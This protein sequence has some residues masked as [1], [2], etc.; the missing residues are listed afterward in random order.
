MKNVATAFDAFDS[1]AI[2]SVFRFIEVNVRFII[3]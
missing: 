2:F 3:T 1:T